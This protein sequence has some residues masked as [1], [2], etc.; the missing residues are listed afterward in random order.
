MDRL[1]E[2]QDLSGGRTA[3]GWK[4]QENE[5]EVESEDGTEL[6]ISWWN[7]KDEELSLVDEQRG[8]FLRWN[9]LLIEE[10]TVVEMTRGF[11]F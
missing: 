11:Y 10:A 9:L 8:R 4:Q 6:C 3:D 1:L 7:L 5:S 2:V